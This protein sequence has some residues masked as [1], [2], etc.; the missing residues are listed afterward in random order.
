MSVLLRDKIN[1]DIIAAYRVGQKSN[2][3]PRYNVVT[4]RDNK[5]KMDIY[6]KKKMLKGTKI[7]IKEDLTVD[8]LKIV[9]EASEKHGF[10]N[11]W[12]VNGNIF[13]KSNNKVEKINSTV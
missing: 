2:N 10:K 5:L 8:R 1:T 13:V 12:T 7:V 9:K 6:N 3:R 11:V 4:F